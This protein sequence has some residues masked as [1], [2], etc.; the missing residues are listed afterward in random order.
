MENIRLAES[1]IY[2]VNRDIKYIQETLE[3]WY[4]PRLLQVVVD[5]MVSLEA[6]REEHGKDHVCTCDM[7]GD[8]VDYPIHLC[9]DLPLIQKDFDKSATN[10][11]E[12]LRLTDEF[13]LRKE[14]FTLLN[15]ILRSH[16]KAEIDRHHQKKLEMIERYKRE[17]VPI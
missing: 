15:D 10:D 11:N 17:F 9:G 3:P 4:S 14:Y 7:E 16:K 5:K 2:R 8:Q 13:N 12:I 6:Y 1:A